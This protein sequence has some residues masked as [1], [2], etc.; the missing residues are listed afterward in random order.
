MFNIHPTY[1]EGSV[2]RNQ[3]LESSTQKKKIKLNL[4]IIEVACQIP[5]FNTSLVL[6]AVKVGL[7]SRPL[8]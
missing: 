2:E 4:R 8:I 3:W 5:N 7:K 1:L 6:V